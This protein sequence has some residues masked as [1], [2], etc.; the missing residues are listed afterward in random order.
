MEDLRKLLKA[1]EI[2][3]LYADFKR[4]ILQRTQKELKKNSDISFDFEEIKTGRKVTS[5][6]FYS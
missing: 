6:R 1:D 4:Y 2:Y 3:P 5:I